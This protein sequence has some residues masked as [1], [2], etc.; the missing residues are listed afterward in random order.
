[1]RNLRY[2]SAQPA[3]DYYIWQVE[4]MLN[5]FLKNGIN[6]N[7]IDIVCS[8]KNQNIPDNWYK[9]ANHYNYV[10]FFFY[11]DERT[12]HVYPSI[13]RPHI[14]KK[15]FAKYPEL[16]TEAIFYHDSDIVFT[17]PVNWNHYLEDDIWYCSDTISYIGANYI[18]SKKYGV[19]ERM[20]EIVN[21]DESIPE[22]NQDNSGGAQYI[23]KNVDH[24]YWE[25]VEKDTTSLYQF[26][27]D[28]LRAFP[29][30]P[31]YHPI[32]KW[33]ADMWAVLWNAWYFGHETKVV[34]DLQF[35]WPMWKIEDWDNIKIFHNAGVTA[36]SG[37]AQ[38]LFYKGKYTNGNPKYPYTDVVL[39][40]FNDKLST[41]K[42]VQ[43]I[44]ET[45]K[46]TCLL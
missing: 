31:K 11:D 43:E 40:D 30:S 44:L 7:N 24:T 18:K 8:V 14:L 39:E 33:T 2:V 23:M 28:H 37:K 10:R 27:L 3:N 20:C 42:Y 1:M 29:E 13:T 9:L 32:Q 6:G 35:V 25:K 45:A 4:I 21:I 19:Y 15:H 36:E 17:Q 41:Y 16:K 5:N 12:D 34:K 38:K 46:K 26:F 22:K